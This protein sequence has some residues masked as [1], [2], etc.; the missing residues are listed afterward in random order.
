M[1]LARDSCMCDLSML[2]DRKSLIYIPCGT[3][4]YGNSRSVSRNWHASLCCY[5]LNV[6]GKNNL[7]FIL[8]ILV[9]RKVF[10]Q[11]LQRKRSLLLKIK[12]ILILFLWCPQQWITHSFF[13]MFWSFH[14][15]LLVIA[16]NGSYLSGRG[17]QYCWHRPRVTPIHSQFSFDDSLNDIVATCPNCW[18]LM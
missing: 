3:L 16:A 6:T 1:L 15:T 9:S 4:T 11:I 7:I 18:V 5:L 8:I 14:K 10:L 13:P 2:R 12:P 17:Y